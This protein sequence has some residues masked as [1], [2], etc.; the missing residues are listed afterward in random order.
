VAGQGAE[1]GLGEVE[2]VDLVI[3]L[4]KAGH[5]DVSWWDGEDFDD[6][7]RDLRHGY[8]GGGG[9]QA[10]VSKE[11]LKQICQVKT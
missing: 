7:E 4:V 9:G 5:T 6:G 3:L 2:E 1:G 10:Y 11:G 8:G